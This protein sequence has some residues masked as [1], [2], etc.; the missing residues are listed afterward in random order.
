MAQNTESTNVPYRILPEEG[1]STCPPPSYAQAQPSPRVQPSLPGQ[2][3]PTGSFYPQAQQAQ[4]EN[5]S[6]NNTVFSSLAWSF[7]VG[8]TT[9]R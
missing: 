7:Y 4:I 8:T 2:A 9:P 6:M 1:G 3:Y 5:V